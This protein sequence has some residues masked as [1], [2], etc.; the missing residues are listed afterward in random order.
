MENHGQ[1]LAKGE[2]SQSVLLSNHPLWDLAFR[3]FFL[4]SSLFSVVAM[5]LWGTY[6]AGLFHGIRF[7][8]INPLVWHFHEMLFGFASTCAL[9]FLLTAVQTW[10]NDRSANGITLIVLMLV[11]VTARICLWYGQLVAAIALQTFWWAICI[12][13]FSRLVLRNQSR[14]NYQ[15]I[16]ILGVLA[17]LN[18]GILIAEWMNRSDIALHLGRTAI[19]MFGILVTIVG[20]RIIPLFTKNATKSTKVQASPRLDV[21]LL[22]VGLIGVLVFF[23]EDFLTLAFNPAPFFLIAGFLHMHRL[24]LWDTGSTLKM[25]ILWSLHATYLFLGFGLAALGASYYSNWVLFTDALHL[26]AVG[27][28]G[29]MILAVISRVSLGHTGR[30]LTTSALTNIAFV[31][32]LMAA[33][34]RFLLPTFGFPIE[35][36]VSSAAL[37]SAA[38][39]LFVVKY[40]PILTRARK[41][42]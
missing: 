2:N 23:L 34:L 11:W 21:C 41:A 37:W 10:T 6:L 4:F 39:S 31:L 27:S 40:F 19:L 32:I 17:S 14:R 25:P 18:L 7:V 38:F 13:I 35:G 9:G 33:L 24:S 5:C 28:I 26:I 42:N 36:W 29:G 16:P 1:P 3:P 30:P 22:V 8:E 15:F 20:G 12:G